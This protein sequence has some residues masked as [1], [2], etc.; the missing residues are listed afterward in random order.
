M[1]TTQ[2]WKIGDCLELM[3]ALDYDSIDVIIADPPY[4][5]VVKNEWDNQWKSFDAYLE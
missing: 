4:Y 3:R 5:K 2:E 1:K